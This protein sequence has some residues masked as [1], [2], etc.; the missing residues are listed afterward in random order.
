MPIRTAAS[1]LMSTNGPSNA[2]KRQPR[3]AVTVVVVCVVVDKVA[4]LVVAVVV[5]SV[6]VEVVPVVTVVVVSVVVD[7]VAVLVVAVVVVSVAVEEVPVVDDADVV[8]CV[9]VDVVVHLSEA[10]KLFTFLAWSKRSMLVYRRQRNF[11]MVKSNPRQP[12]TALHSVPQSSNVGT[13]IVVL[14]A[15]SGDPRVSRNGP[16]KLDR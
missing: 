5:V 3:S 2:P 9:A 13:P 10:A 7:D 12:G 4:V 6:A 16:S 14:R 15:T 1:P 11:L 8:V